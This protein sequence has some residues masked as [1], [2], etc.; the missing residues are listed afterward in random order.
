MLFVKR[1]IKK[2]FFNSNFISDSI[3]PIWDY[4]KELPISD[5]ILEDW[6]IMDTLDGIYAKY[7]YPQRNSRIIKYLIK[8]KI[9]IINN[10]KYKNFFITKLK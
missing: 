6:A 4:K 2:F 5:E 3:I 1:L 7:D 10:N 8:N 9:S